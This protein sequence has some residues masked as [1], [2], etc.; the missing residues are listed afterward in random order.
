MP[1]DVSQSRILTGHLASASWRQTLWDTFEETMPLYEYQCLVCGHQFEALVRPIDTPACESCQGTELER[2]VSRF[3]VSSESTRGA[4][5]GL[6]RTKNK[7]V[8]H[9]KAVADRE[10]IEHHRH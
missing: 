1:T 10:E 7:K 4:S 9:E 5:L 3:A 2:L 6:A 8:L